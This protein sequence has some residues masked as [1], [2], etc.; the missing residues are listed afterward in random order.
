MSVRESVIRRSRT[1]AW[2]SHVLVYQVGIR[3]T[4]IEVSHDE[5]ITTEVEKFVERGYE[6][7][8]SRKD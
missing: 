2:V 8:D 6:M 1:T 3:P 4:A 5:D 7:Q